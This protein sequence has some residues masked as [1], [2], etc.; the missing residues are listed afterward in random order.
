[1]SSSTRSRQFTNKLNTTSVVKMLILYFL[2]DRNYY[3]NELIDQIE[4]SLDY[5]WRPSP[6]MIYPLLR[7]MEDNLLI[8]GWWDEPDKKTK[9]HYKITDT[10]IKHFERIKE[11]YRPQL[12]ESQAIINNAINILYK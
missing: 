8:V 5:H 3:G 2:K 7:N 6:G 12:E 10:G 4:M 1:M 9:R 11:I